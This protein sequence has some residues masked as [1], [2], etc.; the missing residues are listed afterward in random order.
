MS[1]DAQAKLGYGLSVSIFL[2]L[3]DLPLGDPITDFCNIAQRGVGPGMRGG[4]RWR[5]ELGNQ[6]GNGV[7]PPQLSIPNHAPP[8]LVCGELASVFRRGGIAHLRSL[9]VANAGMQVV[10]VSSALADDFLMIFQQAFTHADP[11]AE[12]A[13][14]F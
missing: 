7:T 13:A 10:T 14:E 3:I 4:I 9:L 1:V 2:E 6:G 8:S 11:V 12:I 5:P